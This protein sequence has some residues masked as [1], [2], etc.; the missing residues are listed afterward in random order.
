MNNRTLTLISCL[1]LLST[2]VI[3]ASAIYAQQPNLTAP[4]DVP[5]PIPL[6]EKEKI[7]AEITVKISS[8]NNGGSGVL[9]AKKQQT[10]LVLT[11]AH[12]VDNSK[13]LQI[14]TPDGKIYTAQLVP[15]SKLGNYDLALLQFTS[16]KE[17]SIAQYDPSNLPRMNGDI[18]AVGF[19]GESGKLVYRPG[20][21]TYLPERSLKQG[22]GLGY[23][24]NVVQGMSGGAILN[25]YGELIGINGRSSYPILNSGY[26]YEDNAKPTPAEVQK[27]RGSSWGISLQTFLAQLP[28]DFARAYSFPQ[29]PISIPDVNNEPELTG[30]LGQ[31]NEQARK[32][33]VRINNKNDD[34]DSGSGVIIAKQN[35]TYYVLTCA[36]VIKN[37]TNYEIVTP[38][39]KI[40]S[41]DY[42]RVRKE[43]GV[44]LAVVQFNSNDSY[45]VATIGNVAAKDEQYTFVTGYS[46][47]GNK[48]SQWRFSPGDISE[49]EVGLLRVKNYRVEGRNQSAV[50]AESA[51]SLTGG[52]ELVYRNIT[53]GGMSGGAV[54]DSLGRVIG[55][56]GSAEGEIA[57]DDSSSD[58]NKLQFG[59]SLGIPA[60]TF[61]GIANRLQVNSGLLKV[62]NSPPPD[63]NA[64][65]Q[66]AVKKTILTVGVPQGNA[67]ASVWLQRGNQL[68]R[69][70]RYDEA[71]AAF[72]AAIKLQPAF[73]H[74][75]WYGRGL[76]LYAQKKYS[77]ASV[78]ISTAIS[79]K[80]D[81]YPALK[82]QS[83]VLT[84][85]KQLDEALVAIEKAIVIQPQDP[86]L[87]FI[88]TSILSDLKRYPEAIATIQKGIDISPRAALYW[89]RGNVYVNQ[90]QWDK[91]IN[92][93]NTAIKINPQYANAYLMRGGVYSDQKQ[94]DKAI[95]D[96]N[97]AIKINPQYA[98]AYLMRGDVYSDQ[99]QWDKAI[100]DYNT[101]IKINS[102][103]A[104]AYSAR[105]L[106]Y[107]KQKQWNKAIDDYNTAI[108]INPGDAFA[109]SARGLVYKEQKQWDKAI[110][111]Y[112]T[113]IKIN[114]QYADAYSLRG[115][116]HDQQKQ[117]DKAIDD[118]T[119]AIKINPNNA[120][121][122]SLRGL[123]YVN[124]KQW[125]KAI[126]DFTTAI[127]INPHDAGAY[128]V[129]GLVYQEQ[130]QW[131]KAI[132]D[133]K[134]AIKI[135]PGDASA[136]LSRGEVYSYQKQWDKAI[137]DFK[138]AIKINPNDALAYYNR[139]NVYVNQKQWDLAI[140]DYNSAIKINPQYAEA[141]YNRGIVYSN[142]KKWELALADWNQAIKI[143]PK[144]AEA[145]FNRGFV[146]HTQENYSAA[147]SDYKQALSIN[148]NLIAAI[149][150]I[151]FI[152][153]EMGETEAAIQQ[154]QKVVKV[155]SQQAEPQLALAV[156]MYTK[157]E[158]DK[159]VQLA[160]Q[161]LK[162][163]KQF[164]DV[165][166]LKQNLWGKRIIADTQK[167]FADAKMKAV[168]AGL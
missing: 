64:V 119:T 25:E 27:L 94:W 31:L 157:G 93:Y 125:D 69:L 16:N 141:Y 20:K 82:L 168:L 78:A 146:Y 165:A 112:T 79:K 99:K 126:D 90:K 6:Q 122:Y 104:W 62:E 75:A 132:D 37:S 72:D 77:E 2:P 74:L 109:Y 65:Q 1:L 45:Q 30:W 26:V 87:Y 149:S 136:Y 47:F 96:Y 40:Y 5:P 89:I 48:Q 83:Q 50:A 61:L 11:N 86:N 4:D 33:T 163:D 49:Q 24:S 80:P 128:S 43:E 148:E 161:A 18:L 73:V 150:N 154:W 143:N 34:R 71:I 17:Y 114:P 107:Y 160:A 41:V 10:Y 29:P 127:K 66:D 151:G 102:N 129:R 57:I 139:G 59:Y 121:D 155:D 56:H 60:K 117:W 133:F 53:Y 101:A 54:L 7:A 167:L 85:L 156:A 12:V 15:N 158:S 106:V 123:V 124:Q 23:N 105:G 120:N 19:S 153:Y 137:D 91:A 118:F 22:Y 98:N 97:T 159:G 134:S 55:I 70:R 35:N 142:Q 8:G 108:K 152:N 95:D 52:Y 46:K 92:D 138:S 84:Q 44:D 130:K 36:H 100:D 68:W 135:N 76:V 42:S 88:K 9:I 14:S 63:L 116:V 140:N 21:I 13:N 3:T 39:G 51:I 81:Y 144:F 38:D 58:L 131:D 115:R 103:N 145:Y 113:A 32:F 67:K 162:L 166:Y 147:L 28:Q 164:A 110:D 111:D